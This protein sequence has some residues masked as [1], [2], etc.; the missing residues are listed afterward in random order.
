[1][2]IL[3]AA[4]LCVGIPS[5]A[6][7]QEVVS[8]SV[9]S[10]SFHL[11]GPLVVRHRSIGVREMQRIL[12]RGVRLPNGNCRY[13]GKGPHVAGWSEWEEEVDP[14]TCT[15]IHGQGPQMQAGGVPRQ[16]ATTKQRDTIVRNS[17]SVLLRSGV[18]TV[19]TQAVRRRKVKKP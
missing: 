14:D 8:D 13:H 7:S 18:D 1:M 2:R 16:T 15:T 4:L 9:V 10:D 6:G 3:W 11:I 17:G 19:D 5:L 12:V